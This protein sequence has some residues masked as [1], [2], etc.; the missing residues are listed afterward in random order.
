MPQVTGSRYAEELGRHTGGMTFPPELEREYHEFYLAERRSHV[1]SFNVI[2]FAIVAFTL[3][4]SVMSGHER[5]DLL[6]HIRVGAIALAYVILIWAAYSSLFKNVYLKTASLL[7]AVIALIAAVEVAYWIS[8]GVGEL[9]ALLAAYSIGLYF[10]AGILYHAAVRANMV[11]VLAL[12]TTLAFLGVP[13]SKIAWLT[14]IL[15]GTGS[16]TGI[17]FRH[18][19]IRFRRSFLERGLIA[20]MAARDGLTGLKNRRAFDEHLTRVWQQALN[21]RRPLVVMLSDVDQFKDY[22]DQHGHQ[23][24]DDA[25]KRIAT[26]ID[27]YAKRPLDLAARYGG[28]EL[29]VILFDLPGNLAAKIAEQLRAAVEDLRIE[30]EDGSTVTV[31]VGVAIV[32]PTLE[33]SPEGAVQLADEALY[34]AK[35][36]GRNCV[37]MFEREHDALSTGAFKAPRRPKELARTKVGLK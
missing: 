11:M 14:A 21:D 20:E 6:Q 18:Q 12:G 35:Q 27:A 33:R 26:V 8:A 31:S 7:S 9:F 15:A 30:R 34:A 23:A 22:N 19:G 32:R 28:E 5:A 4:V 37:V 3:L 29:A 36:K 2:M 17:A 1:R 16:I 13:P 10:L 25:L 24:G